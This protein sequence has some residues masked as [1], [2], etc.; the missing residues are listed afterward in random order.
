MATYYKKIAR[1]SIPLG[2]P[3]W[4]HSF[5]VKASEL[6]ERYLSNNQYVV[7]YIFD[8]GPDINEIPV[9]EHWHTITWFN[10]QAESDSHWQDLIA[11]P[12]YLERKEWETPR[13]IVRF[14][15]WEGYVEESI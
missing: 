5:P 2:V 8:Y 7:Y 9:S 14:I 15:E 6:E 13:N 3:T 10:S 1:L 12:I 4:E 11:D